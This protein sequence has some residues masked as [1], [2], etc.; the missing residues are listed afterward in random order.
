MEE[1]IPWVSRREISSLIQK[2][3]PTA[4]SLQRFYSETHK[5]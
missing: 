1:S 5:K 3:E 2:V 4:F